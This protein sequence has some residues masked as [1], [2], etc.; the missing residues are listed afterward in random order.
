MK[1]TWLTAGILAAAGT[2]A[3]PVRSE[4]AVRFGIVLVGHGDYRPGAYRAGYDRGNNDGVREGNHDGRRGESFSFWDEKQYRRAGYESR[5]GSR[6]A[7]QAGYRRAYYAC[8]R[9]GGH[10]S[11]GYAYGYGDDRAYKNGNDDRYGR[12]DDY[13]NDYQNDYPDDRQYDRR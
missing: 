9:D 1:I 5:Y 7:F 11:G 13:Q 10:H 4:A 8:F 3:A 12:N 2:M 6:S